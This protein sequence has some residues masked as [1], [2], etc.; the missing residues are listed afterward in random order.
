LGVTKPAETHESHAESGRISGSQAVPRDH[1]RQ[2]TTTRT[3]DD[4][5]ARNLQKL[6]DVLDGMGGERTTEMEILIELRTARQ[7]LVMV[8]EILTSIQS[9]LE[10]RPSSSIR[11]NLRDISFGVGLIL[12]LMVAEVVHHW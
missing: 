6:K 9:S 2:E 11:G 12:A 8:T 1:F 5:P 4:D 10:T 7:Q 3:E